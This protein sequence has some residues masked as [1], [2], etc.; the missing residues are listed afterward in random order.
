MYKEW[1]AGVGLAALL[2]LP[3]CGGSPTSPSTPAP[4]VL[5]T[6]PAITQQPSPQSVAVGQ[7][8]AFTITA[9]GT[10]PLSYQWKKNGTAI[11]GATLASYTTPV[12]IAGDT[13]A[14][15]MVVIS[16][17]AGSVTSNS[18]TL[19]VTGTT[20]HTGTDVLTYK[21]DVSRSGLNNTESTLTLTNVAAA[22]FGLRRTLAVDG[23][24]DAQPLYVSQLGVSGALHDVALVATEHASVY[25]FD[26]DTGAVLW[27]VSL[28]GSGETPSDTVGCNQVVPEIGITATPVIDRTAGVHGTIF[29]VAMSKS[30]SSTYHQ[31]LHALD[32]VTG[33]ELLGGPT[34]V[35]ATYPVSGGGSTTFDP[36]QYEER[37]ALLLSNGTIYTSWT[38]HCDDQ[39]YTGWVIAFGANTLART[40]VLNVGPNTGTGPAIW[41]SG[42]GPAADAAGN[43]YLLTAN[44]TFDTTLDA[45]G[46][47]NKQNYGNSFL[48]LA[49]GGGTLSVA[50]YFTMSDEVNQSAR[51][52]DFGSGGAMLLPDLKDSSGTVRHLAVGAGKDQN[53][54]VVDR[55]SMGKFN[56]AT[57][58]IWQQLS[59]ALPGGI[60]STPAYFNGVVYY[61]ADNSTLKAFTVTNAKLVNTPQSQT[62]TPFGFPGTAPSVSSNGTANGIV[63]AH[64]NGRTGALHAY[65]A[66]D[67][68]HELYNTNQAANDRDKFGAGN[69]FITP[70]I[71]DGKV[72]LGT[73][74]SV[75]VFGVLP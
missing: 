15:F 49:N 7:S 54:Y 28:L 41:M 62:P 59:G 1:M 43:V 64:E 61:G 37:A 53:I 66:R 68:S 51:D 9:A 14:A 3:G 23:K 11:A 22:T 25:A 10:A 27:K 31:R 39:P 12:T 19:T 5:P 58:A 47:P 2:A 50:D 60:W 33:A 63:W 40:A 45:N 21:N 6:A 20:V 74:N 67:L 75:A 70:T 16:N 17:A 8:A 29:L 69:K 36:H 48:K 44:G 38:S 65:D 72:L 52:E 18:A 46:F 57:N 35:A 42:G 30:A 34:D 24:I 71:A 55:D 13:G 56:P 32:L 73:T 26:A 4:P